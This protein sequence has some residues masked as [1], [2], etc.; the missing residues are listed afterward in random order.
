[1]SLPR[2]LFRDSLSLGSFGQAVTAASLL[3]DSLSTQETTQGTTKRRDLIRRQN[4]PWMS[5][6]Y[7][8]LRKVIADWVETNISTFVIRDEQVVLQ[9]LGLM[10]RSYLSETSAMS[11]ISHATSSCPWPQ[12]LGQFLLL[13]LKYPLPNIQ[14]GVNQFLNEGL[15]LAPPFHLPPDEAKQIF[16]PVLADVEG[17]E[18]QISSVDSSLLATV[19][20]VRSSLESMVNFD[21]SSSANNQRPAS[22][23]EANGNMRASKRLCLS[24]DGPFK[25]PF[26]ILMQNLCN[27]LN[28]N[29]IKNLAGLRAMV[30]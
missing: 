19:D 12:A 6:G 8:R 29:T 21:D 17:K 20:H 14:N 11:S 26:Q 13:A 5:N 25:D 30:E 2:G 10:Y 4:H 9:F 1:M 18:G 3:I 23:M 28:C 27:L 16:L 22:D 24:S 15:Q 7:N